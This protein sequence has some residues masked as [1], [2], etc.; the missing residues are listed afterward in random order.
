MQAEVWITSQ[1]PYNPAATGTAS[2]P[3]TCPDAASLATLFSGT[4]NVDGLY[5]HFMPGTFLVSSPGIRV[6]NHWTIQG[7]GIDLTFA[8]LQDNAAVNASVTVF[9]SDAAVGS[10]IMDLTIDSN[11]AGQSSFL[12]LNAVS[13]TGS[14]TRISRVKAINW[15]ISFNAECF[16][17]ALSN[18]GVDQYTNCVIEDC[19][20]TQPAQ[21]MFGG[22]ATGISVFVAMGPGPGNIR[23]A[24]I[25][26]CLVYDIVTATGG[27]GSPVYFN[28]LQDCSG[29]M[30]VGNKVYNLT[31]VSSLGIYRDSWN[32]R[33]TFITG[34]IIE[35][36][37]CVY[38]NMTNYSMKNVSITNNRLSPLEGG[39]GI[40]YYTGE[41]SNTPL[42][43]VENLLLMNNI[44][45]PAEGVSQCYAVKLSS[46]ITAILMNNVMQGGDAHNS[47]LFVNRDNDPCYSYFSLLK[48]NVF[49]GNVDQLGNKLRWPRCSA[50]KIAS[51][52]LNR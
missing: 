13:L 8:K 3:F 16:V 41:I 51:A 42:A 36:Y 17:I 21:V 34:N 7:A 9:Y 27:L 19:I 10:R 33:D 29:G 23:G 1:G 14:N 25:R 30:V 18:N 5:I 4:L 50:P 31:G 48:F 44:I 24:E 37:G 39:F 12:N 49:A 32:G 47:E 35:A 26:N 40:T 52:I 11:A 45:Y 43:F 22:G 6:Y 20:V 38:Y 2:D 28:A 46:R 15:A